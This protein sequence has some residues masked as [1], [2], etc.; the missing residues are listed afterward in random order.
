[1]RFDLCMRKMLRPSSLRGGLLGVWIAGLASPAYAYVDPGIL[2][3][4]Y[5]M[6]Y[7]A[8]FGI[9]AAV[10]FAPYRYLKSVWRELL[11]RDSSDKRNTD[12]GQPP[13]LR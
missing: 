5:Q 10:V 9:L 2:T 4:L 1:M 8:G 7:V 6:I 12:A 13:E 3:V 11:G